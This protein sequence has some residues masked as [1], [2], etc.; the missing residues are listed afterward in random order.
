LTLDVPPEDTAVIQSIAVWDNI[1][2]VG[3]KT[4]WQMGITGQ[5][6]V[7]GGQDTGYQWDHPA[8]KN[9]Y[10]GWD[11]SAA[12]HNYNWHDA[13]HDF[14]NSRCAKD[15]P[16]P[17]DDNSHGTHTMGT[18]VGDDGG[19]NQIGVAPGARWIG[20]RNMNAG[21][22][23]PAT[24]AEC[25]QWFIAPTDLNNANPDPSQAPHVINNSWSC[26]VSEGCT[27]PNVL[28][29]VVDAVRAAG[30]VT[31]HSAGNSGYAGCASINTPAAIYDASFTV[32]STDSSD[33]IAG[34]SSR[35]PVTVDGSGRLK[36]DVSAPGVGV[37]SSVPTF[38]ASN[39]YGYSYKSGTSMA[40]PHVAGQV[41]LLLAA[42]P[43]LAGNVD[44]IERII[45]VTAV[46][47]TTTQECGGVPG[48]AIPNNTYGWGRVDALG[49]NLIIGKSVTAAAP[50]LVGDSLTYTLSVTNTF[51]FSSTHQVVLTDT[52]PAGTNFITA[53]MPYTTDGDTITWQ[54]AAMAAGERQDVEMVVEV[55]P[56][57]A[58]S[59]IV[60]GG[61]GVRSQETAL[62]TGDALETAVL[63]LRDFLPFIRE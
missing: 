46:P 14:D 10:R 21:V 41:A 5:G 18:M 56:D 27:D 25:Y 51:M 29:V 40:G 33:V 9:Q 49:G 37:R 15:S 52:L 3:A 43:S 60:N 34:S 26:L 32:G 61:Y 4:V 62:E 53:T 36:P 39:P 47:R 17:C 42:R 63:Y 38:S 48:S 16:E 12:D 59:P 50:L 23:T 57:V 2:H 22:G 13:I 35:G 58:W 6:A 11:G 19:S 7:I 24:Y 1:G 44:E 54:W 55:A 28:L 8:I 31:V 20:C 30:I 45:R